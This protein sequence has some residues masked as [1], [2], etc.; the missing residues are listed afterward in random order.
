MQNTRQFWD[1][2]CKRT[3]HWSHTQSIS[4]HFTFQEGQKL[5]QYDNPDTQCT[6]FLGHFRGLLNGPQTLMFALCS[7]L[8]VKSHLCTCTL[9]QKCWADVDSMMSHGI[10]THKSYCMFLLHTHNNAAFRLIRCFL[11]R[12]TTI[13]AQWCCDLNL[14]VD[15]G[16]S[17]ENIVKCNIP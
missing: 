15:Q 12:T 4:M 7:N 2:S 13:V 8:R 6:Q 3:E 1:C 10:L 9:S 16:A 17:L 5:G 11:F 14:L